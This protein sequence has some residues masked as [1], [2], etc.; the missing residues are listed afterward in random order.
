MRLATKLTERLVRPPRS[1][2]L[3]AGT[4]SH[5]AVTQIT[6]GDRHVEVGSTT[7]A[8]GARRLSRYD[9]AILAVPPTVWSAISIRGARLP[10]PIQSGPAVK[11]LAWTESRFWIRPGY[12][13]SGVDDR[14]G[15]LWEGTDITRRERTTS[16]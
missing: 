11:F 4:I 9:Y 2:G 1:L 3:P 14:L 16:T 5:E 12:A 15:Q 13:P 8:G 6:V 10:T 7:P